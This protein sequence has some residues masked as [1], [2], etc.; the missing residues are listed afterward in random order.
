MKV[1][2]FC[3]G[4]GTRMREETEYRPK[5]LVNVNGK[6]IIWHIMKSYASYGFNEFILCVGYKGEMIKDYFMNLDWKNNDFT[7][8]I[9]NGEK[10]IEYHTREEENW[11]VTIVDTGEETMTAGRLKRIEKYIDEDTFMLTYGDGLSNVNLGEVLRYH[12]EK[13][14]VA[15]IT[16]IHPMATFGLIESENGIAVSFSEKPKLT[17]IVNGGFMAL[18][19]R[20]FNYI[21]EKDCMFED[22]PLKNLSEDNELAVRVHDGFWMAIDT[23]KDVKK[24][25]ELCKGGKR[26]WEGRK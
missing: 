17:G 7:L 3:G 15:T 26:P 4:K 16:G 14:K 24:I 9:H 12:R 13:G 19:K 23:F 22:I 11:K 6:P 2:I 21:P 18:S 8:H 25:N 1:V 10:N 5:P 20:I